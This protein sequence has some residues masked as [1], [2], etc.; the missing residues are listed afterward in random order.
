MGPIVPIIERPDAVLLAFHV[1]CFKVDEGTIDGFVDD[2]GIDAFL[3]IQD[4][5]SSLVRRTQ[6]RWDRRRRGS[7]VAMDSACDLT[8]PDCCSLG[9]ADLQINVADYY[10]SYPQGTDIP[11]M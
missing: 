7:I 9:R 11:H 10:P 6:F 3:Y 1:N 4:R 8:Y 2:K 5:A